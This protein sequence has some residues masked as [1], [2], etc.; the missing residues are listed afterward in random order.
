M[1]RLVGRTSTARDLSNDAP[2]PTRH[3]EARVAT[4]GELVVLA[5]HRVVATDDVFEGFLGGCRAWGS[6]E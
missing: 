5:R 2:I 3:N 6:Y 1:V 4:I